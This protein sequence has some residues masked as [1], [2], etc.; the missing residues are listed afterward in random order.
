MTSEEEWRQVKKLTVIILRNKYHP[1]FGVSGIFVP[2][3]K[4]WMYFEVQKKE[5]AERKENRKAVILASP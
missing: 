1:F 5:K 4:G 2:I 3:F